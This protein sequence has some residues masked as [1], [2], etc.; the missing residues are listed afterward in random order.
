MHF[1]HATGWGSPNVADGTPVGSFEIRY[2]DKSSATI[3]LEYGRDLRDWWDFDDASPV[4]RAEAVW[5]DTNEASTAYRAGGVGIR[6]YQLSWTNP[7]PEKTVAAFDYVST[8]NTICAPF[9]VAVSTDW[10]RTMVPLDRN[11]ERHALINNR[12]RQGKVDLLFI[13]DSI[14]EGW[15]GNGKDVWQK[16]YGT[17]QAMNAGISGDRTQHVLW[18]LD[19]GNVEKLSPKLVVLMIGTN[20]F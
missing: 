2:D 12:A 20:N 8:N 9:L 15:E 10:I 3:P 13:G 16:R 5:K 14:T 11:I 7:H 1:L 19:H 17:R 6:L 4:T 18:R